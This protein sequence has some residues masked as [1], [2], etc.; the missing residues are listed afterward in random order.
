M[1]PR[2]SLNAEALADLVMALL[3]VDNGLCMT[4]PRE[5]GVAPKQ[6]VLYRSIPTHPTYLR[7]NT[8]PANEFFGRPGEQGASY[9]TPELWQTPALCS[10]PTDGIFT[11]AHVC[12]RGSGK[13]TLK[14]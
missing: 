12:A 3:S 13:N 9:M 10:S 11:Q 14:L 8:N 1:S 4:L 2:H 7:L 5:L 6:R